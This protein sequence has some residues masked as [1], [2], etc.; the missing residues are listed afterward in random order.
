MDPVHKLVMIIVVTAASVALLLV[1]G[2]V[3]CLLLRSSC[4]TGT[5][6]SND[7]RVWYAVLH[8]LCDS[9]RGFGVASKLR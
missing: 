5:V 7:S 2:F 6:L 8:S 9:I 3:R 1:T 4:L